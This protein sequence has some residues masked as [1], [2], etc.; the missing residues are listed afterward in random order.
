[1]KLNI[2]PVRDWFGYTRRERRSTS[3]LLAI[4]FIIVVSRYFV[5]EKNI[6]LEYWT[7]LLSDTSSV[8]GISD[9]DMNS[10]STLFAYDGRSATYDTMVRTVAGRSQVV[11]AKSVP[12]QDAGRKTL[13]DINSCDSSALEALPGIGPVLSVRIIKYRNLLGGFATVEQLRE[14]YG[15]PEETFDLI[16]G[17]ICA[18][19]S[20]IRKI[21]IN[22]AGYSELSHIHYLE[23]Y[24]VKAILKYI[25][26]EG[27]AN[28]MD[29]LIVNKILTP[30]KAEKV[31][32][33][34]DFR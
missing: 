4:I 23:K 5:P 2:E 19:T 16:K 22:S 21:K 20:G 8:H 32:P 12:G 7:P 24:E 11:R 17:R 18:D 33:Y 30:D 15:L 28:N 34:L 6:A 14:V 29:E 13:T 27:R 26:L 3:I 10:R 31:E 1:M 9:T 25:M